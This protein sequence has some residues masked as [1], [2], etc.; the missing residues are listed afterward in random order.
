MFALDNFVLLNGKYFDASP[1]FLVNNH[2]VINCLFFVNNNLIKVEF[3]DNTTDIVNNF[4][5]NMNVII[6]ASIKTKVYD[7]KYV[8]RFL[9][10][11]IYIVSDSCVKGVSKNNEYTA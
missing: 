7:N 10:N 2:K 8:Y 9:A 6:Y 1:V 5:K 4:K 11:S 3:W